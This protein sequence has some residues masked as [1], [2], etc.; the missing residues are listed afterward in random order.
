MALLCAGVIL[1]SAAWT[2]E[3]RSDEIADQQAL[4]DQSQ[5]LANVTPAPAAEVCGCPTAG[6]LIRGY[7]DEPVYFSANH[8]WRAHPAAD[9]EAGDGGQVY[10]VLSGT[11]ES[12]GQ[13]T[14]VID[15]GNGLA[16]QYRG[17]KKISAVPGQQVRKGAVIGW[18][19]GH[20]A[21]EEEGHVCVTLLKDG[22]AIP[23][24]FTE[25]EK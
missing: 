25:G 16:S 17:L 7:S 21:Y 10:A 15:H 20:V 8:I 12:C 5:R 13:G 3:Q 6:A 4:S 23:L 1:L 9:F 18:A 22:K 24:D 2:R 19:G 14:V 11:V